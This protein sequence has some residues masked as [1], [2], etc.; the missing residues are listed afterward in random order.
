MQAHSRIWC[1]SVG[2]QKI[3]IE[4]SYWRAQNLGVAK[5]QFWGIWMRHLCQRV[6]IW[7]YT[8]LLGLQ[9]PLH[10]HWWHWKFKIL[11]PGDQYSGVWY[12][13][14]Q[15][16]RPQIW[17]FASYIW[18]PK[19]KFLGATIWG[20]RTYIPGCAYNETY[21]LLLRELLLHEPFF[22]STSVSLM[23]WVW[24]LFVIQEFQF[25]SIIGDVIHLARAQKNVIT[26][27]SHHVTHQATPSVLNC[28][29]HYRAQTCDWT[30][31]NFWLCSL[32]RNCGTSHSRV[33]CPITDGN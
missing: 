3:C 19:P 8:V 21:F 18:A 17:G 15:L 28:T 10:H 12:H 16:Q 22:Q 32:C 6:P 4:V 11:E 29:R 2:P 30:L 23:Y 25:H 7:G 24:G 33:S 20:F 5:W 1:I 26:R 9:F 27:L 31:Y 14:F 13:T